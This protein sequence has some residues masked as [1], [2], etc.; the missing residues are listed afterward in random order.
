MADKIKPC[1]FCGRQ[2]EIKQMQF[3]FEKVT[4]F[5]VVC[6]TCG[7]SQGWFF[8]EEDAVEKWNRRV[9]ENA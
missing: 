5:G 3:G 7:I 2:G 9:G 4:R 6:V 8:D 1:P